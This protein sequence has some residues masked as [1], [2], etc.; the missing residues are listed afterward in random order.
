M[1]RDTTIGG[2]EVSCGGVGFPDSSCA[3]ALIFSVERI[4]FVGM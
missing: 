2:G 3:E 1:A 4:R